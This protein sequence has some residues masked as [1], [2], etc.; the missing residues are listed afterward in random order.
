MRLDAARE[1]I[2]P[3]VTPLEPETCRTAE[4]LGRHLAAPLL[5][6]EPLPRFDNAAMD[7]YALSVADVSDGSMSLGAAHRI[8]TGQQMPPGTDAVVPIETCRVDE[9]AGRLLIGRSVSAGANVRRAGEEVGAGSLLLPAGTRLTSAGLGLLASLGVEHVGVH[10]QARI[11][12]LVTGDELTAAGRRPRPGEIRDANGP[13]LAALVEAAGGLPARHGPLRDDPAGIAAALEA[14]LRTADLV[15]TSGGASVGGRD[16]LPSVLAGAAELL[17]RGMAI[18]PGRPILV[19]RAPSGVMM[20]ALP[21][22][23]FAAFVGFHA[24]VAPILRRLAGDPDPLPARL[25]ARLT[26]AVESRAGLDDFVPVRL[27]F[28]ESGVL[29]EPLEQRGSAMLRGAAR[30]DGAARLGPETKLAEEGAEVIIE[31]WSDRWR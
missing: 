13:M 28:G 23:P 18:R 30:A 7:G 3:L 26:G 6:P 29:A 15:C 31:P 1:L 14:G 5:A 2:M 25:T 27:V 24:I 4:A 8:W 17:V 19:A 16:H 21:G 22:N 10:R 12:L 9:P 20:V 11:T